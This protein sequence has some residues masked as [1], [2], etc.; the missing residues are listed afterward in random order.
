[1]PT[2]EK[3]II[4][5]EAAPGAKVE[6]Y[7]GYNYQ[8]FRC[9]IVYVLEDGTRVES[10]KGA[11]LKRDAVAYLAKLPRDVDHMTARVEDGNLVMV[12][13]RFSIGMKPGA[14]LGLVPEPVKGKG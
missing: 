14:G 10:H 13:E 9:P 3:K 4:R 5:I 11:R 2:V 8:N 1:M 7:P 6:K 12:S